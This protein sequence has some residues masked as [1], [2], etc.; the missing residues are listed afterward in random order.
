MK[1]ILNAQWIKS[2]K[3]AVDREFVF[4]KSFKVEK[5]LV[6]ASLEVTALGVYLAKINGERV[7]DFILAPGWTSYR[8]RLQVDTYDVT[9]MIKDKNTITIGVAPG[10]KAS[11]YFGM[12][13]G[14]RQLG[15]SETAALCALTL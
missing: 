6:S 14:D 11:T 7:G 5:E 1:N 3:P 9:S 2:P 15:Y 12:H 8:Y 13:F 10:W 4:S